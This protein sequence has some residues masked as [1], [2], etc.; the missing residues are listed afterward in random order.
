MILKNNW[1]IFCFLTLRSSGLV[2][3][4]RELLLGLI[5]I[6]LTLRCRIRALIEVLLVA[7]AFLDSEE[8]HKVSV[9]FELL[10]KH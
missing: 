4:A 9:W 2:Y 5:A 7:P 3:L 6:G 1:L 8:V 10:L